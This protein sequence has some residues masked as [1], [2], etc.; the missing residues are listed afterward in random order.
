MNHTIPDGGAAFPFVV[1]D[2]SQYQVHEQ[3]MSLRDY[4]AAKAMQAIISST[5]RKKE[6]DK[7]NI[8]P[9][10]VSMTTEEGNL[11]RAATA[12]LAYRYADD[13][14]KAGGHI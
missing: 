14:L 2:V 9:E 6:R 8:A 5:Q 12:D 11:F 7:L 4:F 13:M 10:M 1:Q 3:G